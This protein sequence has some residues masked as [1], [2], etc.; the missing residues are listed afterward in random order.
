MNRKWKEPAVPRHVIQMMVVDRQSRLLLIHRSDKCK[1][2]RNVW[3]LPSGTHEIGEHAIDCVDREIQEEFQLSPKIIYLAHQY[4]N[5]AGDPNAEEHY[6]WVITLF[7]VVV[8]DL[9]CTVNR[10]PELHD[11]IDFVPLNSITSEDFTDRYQFHPSLQE[12]FEAQ[13]EYLLD[14]CRHGVEEYNSNILS[15]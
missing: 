13:G 9:G 10:E 2:A 3:S 11:M 14:A 4:E 5:I 15:I 7:V 6:H 8:D 12:V 1:S